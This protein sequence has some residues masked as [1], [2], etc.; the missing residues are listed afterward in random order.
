[1]TKDLMKSRQAQSAIDALRNVSGVTIEEPEDGFI[2]IRGNEA[3]T[4]VGG[5]KDSALPPP[6]GI[7][8]VEVLKGADSIVGGE[9][10]P[11]GIINVILKRPQKQFSREV[12]LET[13][14]FGHA[15]AA[16]DMTGALTADQSLAGRLIFS[17]ERNRENFLEF[18]G[19]RDAYFAPSLRYDHGGTDLTIG[20]ELQSTWTPQT[21]FTFLDNETMRPIAPKTRIGPANA[22]KRKQNADVYFDLTQ[23]L[24][25]DITL[26]SKGAYTHRLEDSLFGQIFPGPQP[27][28]AIFLPFYLESDYA[29]ASIESTLEKTIETG[30]LSHALLGGVTY[31]NENVRFNI[32]ID[33]PVI[34]SLNETKLAPW[35]P[36]PSMTRRHTSAEV[37]SASAFVQDQVNWGRLHL[38]GSI[39]YSTAWNDNRSLHAWTPN[40]G[41]SYD[42]T[43]YA[44]VYASW[45]NSYKAS[46]T[47][48]NYTSSG[49]FLPAEEGTTFESGV[50]LNLLDDRLGITAAIYQSVLRNDSRQPD[51]SADPLLR[52]LVPD[53]IR[54]GF[55]LDMNGEIAIGWNVSANYTYTTIDVPES[56]FF[57][58][59]ARHRGSLWTTY[60]FQN[61]ALRGW[62][63]GAG[64]TAS[65]GFSYVEY[66]GADILRYT[67]PAQASVDASIYWKK[68]DTASLTLGV[69]NLFNKTLYEESIVM[70]PSTLLYPALQPGRTVLLTSTF[71][72]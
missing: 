10:A 60:D 70:G 56:G 1:V 51:D 41:S 46:E 22:G 37:N 58:I 13:G 53:E 71:K 33:R 29:S 9:M 61:D 55:E 8:R 63:I 38:L 59:P 23:E 2:Y 68:N 65:T 4:L 15:M 28:I 43:D 24:G 5:M 3:K 20:G 36:S 44:T 34:A 14:S 35:V 39:T 26:K 72:F 16:Y 6:S 30:P 25:A 66:D 67:F 49:E 45:M 47:L 50:K 40:V 19:K 64:V 57:I 12:T 52:I 31:K 11:S 27:D 48:S 62:G 18:D 69:K 17:G 42:L 7:E 21:P 54:R 32:G